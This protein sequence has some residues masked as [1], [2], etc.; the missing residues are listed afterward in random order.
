MHKKIGRQDSF[1]S[2]PDGRYVRE[3]TQDREEGGSCID[4][5]PVWAKALHPVDLRNMKD[6]VR[7][8]MDA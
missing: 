4:R 7:L 6:D 5:G 2:P 8:E 1:T 3:V